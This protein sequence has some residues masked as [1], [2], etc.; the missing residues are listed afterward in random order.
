MLLENTFSYINIHGELESKT[1]KDILSVSEKSII[2]F[3]PKNDTPWCTIE[4]KD[5][6]CLKSEFQQKGIQLIWISKDTP[7][8]HLNFRD[9]HELDIIQIS[10][11]DLFLHKH[12]SA[13]WEKNN[14]WKIILWVIRSTFLVD[15]E[16]N[17]LKSW[18]NV[19]AK[20]HAE[21]VVREI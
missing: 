7:E 15:K 19:R 2:F 3:Y 11:P 12:F 14:Y 5:F 8:S 21:K 4:N 6:S 16:W 9:K 1:L 17:I 13:Y 18:K 20:W 10:D